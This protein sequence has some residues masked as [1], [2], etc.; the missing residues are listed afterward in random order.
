M[1]VRQPQRLHLN[2]H[3]PL[4]VTKYLSL[5]GSRKSGLTAKKGKEEYQGQVDRDT[6]IIAHAG[7][8]GEAENC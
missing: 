2:S 1:S 5:D 7:Q 4:H 3:L 6:E 8:G